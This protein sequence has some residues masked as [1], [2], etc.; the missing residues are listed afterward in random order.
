MLPRSACAA[1]GTAAFL[2]LT[3]RWATRLA[4]ARCGDI[5]IVNLVARNGEVDGL[6]GAHAGNLLA[7]GALKVD[8]FVLVL[9]GRAF[10][11]AKGVVGFALLYHG[12][13]DDSAFGEGLNGSVE[14]YPI[15]T[16]QCLLN[17]RLRHGLGA[18][19]QS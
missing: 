18:V 19:G 12:L 7:L 16:R 17:G 2:G 9:L 13:V 11:A 1:V 6:V 14:G 5:E 15:D 4:N 10:G 8:V 3:G